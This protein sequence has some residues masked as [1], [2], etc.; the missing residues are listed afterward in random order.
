MNKEY[1]DLLEIE[2]KSLNKSYTNIEKDITN[3]DILNYL[4]ELLFKSID[5]ANKNHFKQFD[6]AGIPYILHPLAVMNLIKED[7]FVFNL[8]CKI[9][10]VLHDIIEDTNITKEYLLTIF[11]SF[12]VEAIDILSK[13]EGQS[14][15]SYFKEVKSNRI[16]RIVKL[17][18]LT[19]NI[20][21]SRIE[22]PTEKD[23]KRVEVYKEK[24]KFLSK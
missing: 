13:K 7:D 23:Y 21:I 9:V 18:D 20:D 6:K 8:S 16:S 5:I 2:I 4:N 3:K 12:I 10:A 15:N 14:K 17:A 24:Y 22:N 1:R 19:H 11:P